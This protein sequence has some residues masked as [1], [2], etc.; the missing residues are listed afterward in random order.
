MMGKIVRSKTT[1]RRR[2]TA[3][4][5]R[6][7]AARL[8]RPASPIIPL[9][10]LAA[11]AGLIMRLDGVTASLWVDEFGT[12][13]AVDGGFV[14]TWRRALIFH[15]Q[16]PFYYL[17]DWAPFHAFGQSEWS[18]RILSLAC[19]IALLLLVPWGVRTA[20]GPAAGYYALVL[21]AF[22]QTLIRMSVNARPYGLALLFLG[23]TVVGFLGVA[24]SGSRRSRILWVVGAGLTF[25]SHYVFAP[26]IVGLHA[27]YAIIPGLRRRYPWR[28]YLADA[29]LQALF[30]AI[31]APHLLTLVADSGGLVWLDAPQ[32][33]AVLVYVLPYMLALGLSLSQLRADSGMA[34]LRAALW[35]SIVSAAV[36]LEALNWI[37]VDLLTWHYAHGILIPI[38]ILSADSVA[39]AR[40]TTRAAAVLWLVVLMGFQLYTFKRTTGSFS[41][42]GSEDWR[43]AVAALRAEIGQDSTLPI[44]YR[45][46]M[47]EGDLVLSGDL[48]AATLAPLRSPGGQTPDWNVVPLTYRWNAPGC[49]A[50]FSSR[51]A[52]VLEPASEFFL[53]SRS[54]TPYLLEMERWVARTYPG[55]FA[56][57]QRVFGDVVVVKYIRTS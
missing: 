46:G 15:R 26:V 5:A 39:H 4:V 18:L 12:L 21:C 49:D 41:G 16:T 57:S 17:L 9:M 34:P 6:P 31:T 44:L 45:S 35:I 11:T 19:G 53:L 40:R 13:W 43:G 22:D 55:K 47:I 1:L 29:G 14:E 2:T 28:R 37:G 8:T 51:V 3:E 42:V 54:S 33:A 48:P 38:I 27:A 25:W 52:P 10:A 30:V 23:I 24:K 32:R 36:T 7:D 20:F 50:Y 56:H